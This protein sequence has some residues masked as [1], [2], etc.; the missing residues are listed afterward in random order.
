M[1]AD[2]PTFQSL[3]IDSI[4]RGCHSVRSLTVLVTF[5]DCFISS[6]LDKIMKFPQFTFH[7]YCVF[8]KIQLILL[9]F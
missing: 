1:Y 4:A 7:V 5:Y 9:T 3:N 6:A 2:M 8:S